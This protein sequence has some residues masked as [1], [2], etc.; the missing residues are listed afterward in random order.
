MKRNLIYNLAVLLFCLV[1]V[2]C[3]N[4]DEV[5]QER[6]GPTTPPSLN[7]I[8][9]DSDGNAVSG[10]TVTFFSSADDYESD[11]NSVKETTTDA[12]GVATLLPEDVGSERGAYYFS[13]VSGELTNGS[14]TVSSPYIYW[15]N[16]ATMIETSLSE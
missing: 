16:G 15:T 3:I 1:C 14:S 11:S 4:E 8:V 6:E 12:D 5:L 9:L 7:I 10:A 2:S 13:A